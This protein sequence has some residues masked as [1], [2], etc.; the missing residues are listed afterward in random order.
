MLHQCFQIFCYNSN[1]YQLLK[2]KNISQLF[3]F[4]ACQPS[5]WKIESLCFMQYGTHIWPTPELIHMLTAISGCWNSH[6]VPKCLWHSGKYQG[7]SRARRW[8]IL[9]IYS[10]LDRWQVLGQGWCI[11]WY[12]SLNSSTAPSE[13]T[14]AMKSYGTPVTQMVIQITLMLNTFVNCL[15][16]VQCCKCSKIKL[17]INVDINKTGFLFVARKLFYK[18]YDKK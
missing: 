7:S 6:M 9:L 14:V 17:F 2:K 13:P 10:V 3:P 1:D 12:I 5:T 18:Q 4:V 16:M 15:L 11:C 8:V